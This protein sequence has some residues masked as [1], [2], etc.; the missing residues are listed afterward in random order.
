MKT[1]VGYSFWYWWRRNRGL[2]PF[3]LAS[4]GLLAA[5][6]FISSLFSLFQHAFLGSYLWIP[7]GQVAGDYWNSVKFA[8]EG[9]FLTFLF[10]FLLAWFAWWG[11]RR[12]RYW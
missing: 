12:R 7:G 9:V 2:L 5:L 1:L 6:Y 4:G 11:W 10:V 3:L 8:L